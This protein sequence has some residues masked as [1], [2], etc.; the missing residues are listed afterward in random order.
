MKPYVRSLSLSRLAFALIL[1]A[2]SVGF[3]GFIALTEAIEATR[4]ELNDDGKYI[5]VFEPCDGCAPREF[6]FAGGVR[7]IENGQP[8][9][10]ERLVKHNGNPATVAYDLKSGHVVSVYWTTR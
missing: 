4:I 10:L 3:G 8:S 9:S 7:F 5:L 1:L 6:Q 2:P